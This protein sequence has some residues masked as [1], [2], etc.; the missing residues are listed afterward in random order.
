[1][2]EYILAIDQGT[3]SSRAILFDKACN[4]VAIEQEEITQIFKHPGWVEEDANEIW[5]KTLAVIA[6]VLAM[7]DIHPS[8]I[9]AIGITNQRETTVVWD[10][11]TGLPIH[12]AVVWQS[13]QSDVVCEQWSKNNWEACIKNKTGLPIDP[14][15]SASKIR[16]ILDQYTN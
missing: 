9:K 7:S 12:Y 14:Y 6:K 3:T 13:R 10:K 15:L 5:L 16:W 4:V 1:M 11:H 2:K 8:Q